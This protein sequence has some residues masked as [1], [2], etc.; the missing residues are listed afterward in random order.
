V[1]A[2]VR[3]VIEALF[4]GLSPEAQ[5]AVIGGIAGGAVGGLVGGFFTLVGVVVGLFGEPMVRRVGKVRCEIGSWRR[6]TGNSEAPWERLLEVTFFN[7]KELPVVVWKMQVEF[8]K[9]GKH[10][11]DWIHPNLQ[12]VDENG[13]RSTLAPVNLPSREAVPKTI[14]VNVGSGDIS[15]RL[16]EAL[17]EADEAVFVASIVGAADK[18]VRLSPPWQGD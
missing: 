11:E 4:Q 12:V 8:Y 18:R 7:G 6:N 15:Q 9:G 14:G 1:E 5:A 3:R 13:Q 10:L 2:G 17:A 16:A